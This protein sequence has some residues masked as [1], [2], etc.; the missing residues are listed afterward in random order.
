V[1]GDLPPHRGMVA[2]ATSHGFHVVH[3]VVKP[4]MRCVCSCRS[5][6]AHFVSEADFERGLDDNSTSR[7]IAYFHSRP[8]IV[9]EGQTLDLEQLIAE[10]NEHVDGF[11]CRGSGFILRRIRK[12]TIIFVPFLPLGG[13]DGSYVDTPAWLYR[14]HAVIN[15]K[16]RDRVDCFRFAVLSALFPVRQH[17]DRLSSYIQHENVI[18]CSGLQFPLE[19]KQIRVFEKNNPAIGIHCLAYNEENKSFSVLYLSSD[20]HNRQH[21]ISLLL[22]DSPDGKRKHYVWIKNLSRLI[23]SKY[24]KKCGRHVCLSCLQAFTSQRVLED[25]SRMCLAH[26]PQQCEY[27]QG[28]KAKLKFESHHFE[29]PFDFYLVADFECILKPPDEDFESQQQ[30]V[31]HNHVPSGFC[32]HRVSAHEDYQTS[33]F[34]YSGNNVMKTFFDHVFYQA[35]SINDILSRNVP[36]RPLTAT[37]QAEHDQASICR[38]CNTN[39][40][41]QNPKT[42]HHSHVTGQYLFPA[43]NNCNLALKPRKC[44]FSSKSESDGEG[45]GGGRYM[46]PLIFHN[47]SGY[48][49]HFVLQYFRKEYTEYTK[50][51]GEVSYADIGVIPLNGERNLLLT[52]GN[53]VFIDSFQFLA[54]SLDNLVKI[55]RKSGLQDF[56][57]T[58]RHFGENEMFYQKGSYPYDYVSDESKFNDT[59]LPPKSAFYNRLTDED[60]SD[61]EYERAQKIWSHFSMTSLRQY[62]DFY[63]TLDVLLLADVFEKFRR[64]MLKSHG[65]DCLHFP[66]LPSMTWQMALKVTGVELELVTDSNIYLMIESAIRGGLSFVSQ[67]HAKANFPGMYNYRSD[68]PTSF[69][70]YLDCNSLYSTCQTYSLP[71]GDFKFLSERELA[72]FDVASVS[73]D[74]E[75]GYFVECDLRYPA[76]LHDAHNAYPLAPEHLRIDEEMLSDTLRW[77]MDEIGVV[78]KPC[79]KLVSNL[80]DKSNYVAHYRCLQFYLKHGLELTKI[81]RVVSFA[82]RPFM[83][84]FIKYCNE[85]RKNAESDFESGLYKLLANA[86]YGKT[87]ENIRKRTNVRLISD[88][89]KFVRAVGKANYKRSA[90]INPDLVMLESARTKIVMSKPIAVGCAILEIAKLIMYEFYYDCLLPKFGEKLSLCFT[91]TDSFICHIET[92]DLQADLQSLSDWLDTSNFER[93]HPLFSDANRRALGKF[94][95]E[96]ADILPTEFVGLRS[97]MYSLTT[98]DDSRSFLKAKGVPRSYVM[99]NVRHEEYLHVLKHWSVTKCKFRAF[100]S[101]NHRIATRELVKVCLSCVDDKRHLLEDA[102]RSLAYG[103]RNIPLRPL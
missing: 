87:V 61:D 9:T 100:R 31:I 70:L 6:R 47:L 41:P 88:P 40:S 91:D 14:K 12:L 23:H 50:K 15:V 3:I 51:N 52:I 86:F 95:S 97:K 7:I 75:T 36:M 35:K 28:E 84:P 26:A 20:M 10:F 27:P 63:L 64:T 99:K 103:H 17:S 11:T 89:D 18:D 101:R 90:I 93:N 62:H 79:T 5:L 1:Q 98:L 25:H 59:T 83:Q 13:G 54:T 55:M 2:C 74:S 68:L 82:Q 71:V 32:V 77:M 4:V 21:K 42:H 45:D 81:H 92:P 57:Q 66:S 38:N 76:H 44:K 19:P 8:M 34:T 33:P 49:G 65:L 78:H 67:R 16:C 58:S 37:E 53:V 94:K 22:L 29:F 24:T 72:D 73:A 80:C 30:Q 56:V 69:L 96:T 60:I 46:V 48:D 43:C 39:F 102:I 85:G